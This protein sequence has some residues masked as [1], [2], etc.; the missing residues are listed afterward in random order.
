MITFAQYMGA[1]AA[2]VGSL[3]LF[4]AASQEQ[5]Q[6]REAEGSSVVHQT[7]EDTQLD[8]KSMSERIFELNRQHVA[9]LEIIAQYMQNGNHEEN[10]TKS[11]DKI[12]TAIDTLASRINMNSFG[13]FH[14]EKLLL[15]TAE[16][17]PTPEPKTSATTTTMAHEPCPNPEPCPAPEPC[18]S[19]LP[20]PVSKPCPTPEQITTPPPCPVPQ[21]QEPCPPPVECP[22]IP[23]TPVPDIVPVKQSCQPPFFS[24][25]NQCL[26]ISTTARTWWTARRKCQ[27]LGAD[28][29]TLDA[30]NALPLLVEYMKS[31]ALLPGRSYWVGGYKNRSSSQH[32]WVSGS[33]VRYN[34][35]NGQPND[36]GEACVV[37]GV[38]GSLLFDIHC[39]RKEGY[40]CSHTKS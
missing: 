30:P 34:W 15:A 36:E 25:I 12:A 32:Y 19:A 16:P 23:T 7:L 3:L 2:M 39:G 11:L 40:I 24:V 35:Q 29:V 10:L 20:C 4:V 28:L 14:A 17:T 1:W 33:I 9:S 21:P 26:F 13:S 6:S 8:A 27:A 37:I 31:K 5:Q 18:P 38:P 22:T